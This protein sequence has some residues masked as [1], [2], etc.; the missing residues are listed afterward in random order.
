MFKEFSVFKVFFGM[1]YFA[2]EPSA[3]NQLLQNL[4]DLGI[5]GLVLYLMLIVRAFKIC[6]HRARSYI[7]GFISMMA[8]SMTLTMTGSYKPL[9]ILLTV[10]AL[11]LPNGASGDLIYARIHDEEE[12]WDDGSDVSESADE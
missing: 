2:Y 7:P 10:L 4:L 3:H 11:H 5:I 9:W 8:L 6:L 12:S 1:G